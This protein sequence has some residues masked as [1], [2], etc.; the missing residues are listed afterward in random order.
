MNVLTIWTWELFKALGLIQIY[1]ITCRKHIFYLF[2]FFGPTWLFS[3][4]LTAVLSWAWAS[5]GCT[6]ASALHIRLVLCTLS[7]PRAT[8]LGL[9]DG[10]AWKRKRRG[11]GKK[12]CV[13]IGMG[14][15]DLCVCNMKT[16][17]PLRIWTIIGKEL[18]WQ[19]V[20]GTDTKMR[21]IFLLT[22]YVCKMSSGGRNQNIMKF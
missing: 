14:D 13:N 20:G 1:W 6:Q 17:A 11:G 3:S 15:K 19:S 2:F 5:W 21:K 4:W 18:F 9:S 12:V 16:H 7:P 22:L 10:T 8:S